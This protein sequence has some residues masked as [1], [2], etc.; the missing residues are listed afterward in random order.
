[1]GIVSIAFY[2]LFTLVSPNLLSA[3]IGSVGLMIAFYYG[4]T[5]FACAWFYRK[6]LASSARNLLMQGACPAARRRD[7]ARSR[8]ATAC[9]SS[10]LPD[11]LTDDDGE[12]VTIFG[13]GAVGVVGIGALV[14]GVGSY[15]RLV[16]RLARRTSRARPWPDARRTTWSRPAD[17]AGTDARRCGCPDSGLPELVIA[18]DLSNLPEGETAVDLSTGEEFTKPE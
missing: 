15:G 13:F 4:L 18:P 7:H 6:N 12:N 10:L 17:G 5:G 11:W 1:M 3:L 9:S 8:S 14:L 16:G 2:L